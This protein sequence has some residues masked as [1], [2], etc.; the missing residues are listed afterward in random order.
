[1]RDLK[2]ANVLLVR[3]D[4]I[5]GVQLGN[6]PD[7][8]GHYE[9]KITDFGLA[10][11]LET[12]GHTATGAVM[13]T[14]SYMAP[15][16]AGGKGKSV[17]P[18]ADQYALGAILYEL[19]TGRP[20][21]RAAT[22]LDTVLLV[23]SDD[24]VP[25]TRLNPKTPRDLETIALKCLAKDPAKRYATAAA[26]ADDLRRFQAGEPIT[27]RPAGPIEKAVKWAKR[28]PALAAW[29]G[30]VPVQVVAGS[31]IAVL[32]GCAAITTLLP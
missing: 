27:A 26:L 14:P 16:Q 1:H 23:V 8:S 10:K 2:P 15:E 17:G 9:P 13:G 3:S 20:P 7:E 30:I 19:L 6:S 12:P 25:P 24:P 22:P 21:F 28:N 29:I 4:S 31:E 5:H 32:V 11:R 18:P